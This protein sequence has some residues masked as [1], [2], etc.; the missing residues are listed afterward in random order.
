[1]YTVQYFCP[2]Q[3]PYWQGNGQAPSFPAAVN[4]AL[5]L[6]PPHGSARV[7]DPWGRV[8]YEI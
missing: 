8:V 3:S 7:I 1:M 2:R 4:L 6:K 5:M